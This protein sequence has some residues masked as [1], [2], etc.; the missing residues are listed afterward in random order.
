MITENLRKVSGYIEDRQI[1]WFIVCQRK[2]IQENEY[3]MKR[4]IVLIYDIIGV[5]LNYKKSGGEYD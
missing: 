4:Q 3:Y 5:V 1:L 2:Y